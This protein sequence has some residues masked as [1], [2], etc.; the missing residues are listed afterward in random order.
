M[1]DDIPAAP[2]PTPANSEPAAKPEPEP[3]A[4]PEP[5]A[6]P[7]PVTLEPVAAPETIVAVPVAAVA[8]TPPPP[9]PPPVPTSPPPAI[10]PP[11]AEPWAAAAAVAAASSDEPVDATFT[12]GQSINRLWGIPFIGFAIRSIVLIPHFIALWLLAI[13]SAIVLLFSWIPVLVTG[14][15]AGLVTTILGGYV[16]W[17]IRVVAYLF[18][19]SATY[20]PFSLSG[21]S[22]VNVRIDAHPEIHRLWGIPLIGIAVRSLLCI[23]HYIALFF[24]GIVVVILYYFTWLP[25]LLLGRQAGPVIDLVGG[26]WRWA[27]RVSAYVLLL[28]NRYPPFRLNS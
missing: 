17:L 26:Y 24:V 1:T 14:R 9:P 21:E 28:A 6:E 18:L 15:Q 8:V 7:E 12:Y 4:K 25:V 5:E 19:I 3:A 16:R 23:P 2:D 27:T 11:P 22:S 10:A 13:A 20:P